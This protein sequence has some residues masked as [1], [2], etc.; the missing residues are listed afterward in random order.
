MRT[1]ASLPPARADRVTPCAS[2]RLD[3]ALPERR[4]LSPRLLGD[5]SF[6]QMDEVLG[7]RSRT[8]EEPRC[9]ERDPSVALDREENGV[10]RDLHF[11]STA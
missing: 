10:E 2:G 6:G 5:D 11:E 4:A 7:L 3:P 1:V 9:H 8:Q